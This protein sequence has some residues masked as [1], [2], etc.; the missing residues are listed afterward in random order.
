MAAVE[1][2]LARVVMSEQHD[3]QIIELKEKEGERRFPIVIGIFEVH[4]IH[5]V[6]NNEPPVRPLTHELLSS[7]LRELNVTVERVIVN[8]LRDWTFFARIILKQNGKTF[9]IDSR[10]SDAMALAVHTNAAIYV[11]ERVLE[12]ASKG[13]I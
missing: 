12:E 8:D 6:V 5:R 9:D 3:R 2:E 1:C 13:Y 7:I 10:P 4:A 11:E